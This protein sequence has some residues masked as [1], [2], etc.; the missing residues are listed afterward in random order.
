MCVA[1][2]GRVADFNSARWF[3]MGDF[4]LYVRLVKKTSS[5]R[6]I[7]RSLWKKSLISPFSNHFTQTQHVRL[8]CPMDVHVTSDELRNG[9][10]C[11]GTLGFRVALRDSKGKNG[12]VFARD[13]QIG[14]NISRVSEVKRRTEISY[15]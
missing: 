6:N 15:H 5:F 7:K 8:T 13:L 1:Q 3:V 10:V 9:M 2:S 11:N 4:I 12:G 14:F